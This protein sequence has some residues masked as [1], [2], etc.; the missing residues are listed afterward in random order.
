[1]IIDK[2]PDGKIITTEGTIIY[3]DK[4]EV[5]KK[6]KKFTGKTLTNEVFTGTISGIPEV[7]CVSIKY[8]LEESEYYKL[9]I[10]NRDSIKKTREL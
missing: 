2:I 4:L 6:S 8:N 3:L 7:N 10:F 5:N 9:E 1:M